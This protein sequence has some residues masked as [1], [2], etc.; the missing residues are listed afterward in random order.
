MAFLGQDGFVWAIGV[1]EDRFDPE[2]QGRV[3][4]R[5]L[6]YHTDEKSRILTKDL[7]WAQVMQPVSSNAMSGVG[8][9]PVNLVE[10]SWVVGF[11]RDPPLMQDSIV[12][13]TMPGLNTT[14]ALSGENSKQWAEYRG[15]YTKFPQD[16]WYSDDTKVIEG[17]ET[18]YKD[19]QKGYFD[20]TVDQRKRPA[21]PSEMTYMNRMDGTSVD[22]GKPYVV[23]DYEDPKKFPRIMNWSPED[24]DLWDLDCDGGLI[25]AE[26]VTDGHKSYARINHSDVL[27]D[28]FK[29]TRRVTSDMRW[30]PTWTDFGKFQWPDTM[31]YSKDHAEKPTNFVIGN[32]T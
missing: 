1:V 14:T 2:K 11:F 5:W 24:M 23:F 25:P 10:G 13:G 26:F 15:T 7:P 31:T 32:G 3:R 17:S 18:E 20:P 6:G 22:L 27:H 28:M 21:P 16:Q 29:T 12:I 8:D 4:V 19:Y 30:C 9:A